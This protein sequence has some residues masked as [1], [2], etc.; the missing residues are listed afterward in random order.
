MN[1]MDIVACTDR[2]FVMPTGVMMQSVCVNNLD[3]D[4]TFHI[5]LDDDVTKE[6]QHDLE[7]VVTSFKGKSV[8]FYPVSEYITKIAFPAL[9]DPT[10]ANSPSIT[11]TTYFRL[12]LAEFLP[13]TIDKV[14]YLDGDIIVRHSLLPLWI[15]DLGNDAVAVVPD[16]FNGMMEIYQR[17][18]YPSKLCYFNAGVMLVN[19]KYWREH[20]VVKDF[21]EYLETHAEDILYQD[22][23]VLNVVFKDKKTILPIKYN[24]VSS[25][26][27]KI[28]LFDVNKFEKELIEAFT[29]PVIVHFIAGK[30]WYVYQRCPHPF[31]NTWN[32]YQNQTKWK[33][34]KIEH[35][36]FKLRVINFMADLL[37]KWKLKA[38]LSVKDRGYID[39][40]PID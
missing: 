19:L 29:D 37:R 9:N 34:V 4:I 16:G 5:V 17:L 26:L 36:P 6:D 18:G 3:V 7:N 12:W 8:E 24:L 40:N 38:Q 25:Y 13:S 30:P 27:W 11:R 22:Q 21:L 14:L 23:D 1:K 39:I 31:K 20:M 28:P 35:R 2:G 33:G 15:T 10:L 32:K